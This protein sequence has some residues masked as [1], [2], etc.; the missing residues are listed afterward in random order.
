MPRLVDGDNLLGMWPGRD[1][2][3][4]E[5]RELIRQVDRLS[6]REGGRIVLVF[7]GTAPVWAAFPD[8]VFSGAGRSADAVILERL[9]RE[10]DP[11]NW[12]VVTNDRSLAD[13]CRAIGARVEGTKALRIRLSAEAAA[14]KTGGETDVAYWLEQFGEKDPGKE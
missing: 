14:E 2:S 7:D 13:R 6:G 11:R 4:A 3:D 8:V 12:T 5:K 10:R 9:R 1:R